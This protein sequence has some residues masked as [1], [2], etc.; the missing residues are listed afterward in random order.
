MWTR[1]SGSLASTLPPIALTD[2]VTA[3]AAAFAVLVAVQSGVGQV[4]DVN[5][6]ESLLQLMGPLPTL[7][8]RC[9]V[10]Q[11]RLGSG[12]PYT[13]PRGTYRCADGEWVAIS[14]SSDSIAE[15]VMALIGLEDDPRVSTGAGR[16]EHR[17]FLEEAV[18]SWIAERDRADVLEAFLGAD[19]AAAPIYDMEELCADP[20]VIERKVLIEA[21]GYPMTGPVARLSATPAEIRW[22]GRA[23]G[24][25]T[26]SVLRALADPATGSR[27]DPAPGALP[28]R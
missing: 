20:H 27:V 21:E 23:V 1:R 12:L 24:R 18:G 26:E 16:M 25:D 2:E 11:P 15:R 28:E 17:E 5:L 6:L 7:W 19:A 3:L 22:P 14:T 4:V 10:M 8:Q 13:A 9:G